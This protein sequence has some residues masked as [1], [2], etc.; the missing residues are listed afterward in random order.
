MNYPVK[1]FKSAYPSAPVLSGTAGALIALLDACLIDGWGTTSISSLTRSGTVATATATGHPF[2]EDQI[3]TLAGVN[4]SGW[5]GEIKAINVTANTFQFTVSSGLTTPATGTITAKVA[6]VGNWSKAYSGTNLAVYRSSDTNGVTRHYLRVDDSNAKFAYVV[7][8]EEMTGISTGTNPYPTAAQLTNGVVWAKSSTADSTARPWIFA[9]DGRSVELFTAWMAGSAL[10]ARHPFGEILPLKAGDLY[11]SILG[12]ASLN[13]LSTDPSFSSE[14]T[15]LYPLS[16]GLREFSGSTNNLAPI[17]A[18]RSHDQTTLSYGYNFGRVS[19]YWYAS[20]VT[21][22]PV[23]P[24][25]GNSLILR[26]PAFPDPVSGGAITAR[27]AI[28]RSSLVRGYA[29]GIHDPCH[30]LAF[31]AA[32]VVV[33]SGE[34]GGRALVPIPVA[35]YDHHAGV[36]GDTGQF[37]VDRDGPW[38]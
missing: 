27:V 24:G 3:L 12:G 18:A 2:V 4:E 7:A 37:L 21:L 1:F 11:H 28:S 33:G 26:L 10:Y 25:R 15:V 34:L 30:H 14:T 20:A 9:A 23:A 35:A 16:C 32:D 17:Y 38:R 6:P 8:Y 13:S 5:N 19:S 36:W 22:R 31:T 29:P